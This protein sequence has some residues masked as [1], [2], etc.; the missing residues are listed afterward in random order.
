MSESEH[1]PLAELKATVQTEIATWDEQLIALSQAIHDDPEVAFT[2]YR[3]AARVA[4]VMERAGFTVHR[5]VGDLDTA[6]IA[7]FGSGDFRVALCAEYDALPDIG[8]GCG[9]NII[10]GAAVGA[11]IALARVADEL[12]LSVRL[13]GTP[14]E[15]RG[16][17]KILLL[18][19]G[20]FDDVAV[21][22]MVHPDML[23]IDPRAMSSMAA[24]K[25]SAEYRGVASHAGGMPADGVN[26]GS[27][28]VVAQVA[29]GLLRQHLR[30]GDNISSVVTTA[31]TDSATIP[32][33]AVVLGAVRSPTIDGLT[34]LRKRMVQCFE[35]AAVATGCELQITPAM[36][37]YEPLDQDPWLAERFV[38]NMR[39]VGR[40]V[41]QIASGRIGASTDM[42]NVSRVIPS[43]HP[44]VAIVGANAAGHSK[45]YT[46]VAGSAA[47]QQTLRDGAVCLAWTAIDAAADSAAREGYLRRRRRPSATSTGTALS[48]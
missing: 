23:N 35:G 13:V 40:E 5:G 20:A 43:I 34:A 10:A 9:H 16:G 31:G 19:N 1:G 4:E 44:Q 24:S 47:G 8:H 15:E 26:A 11:A 25:F 12:G 39:T 32:D 18:E 22:M 30:P 37:D 38:R 46:V 3:A 14:A 2:E 21:A 17:G 48:A 28:A 42:G 27:A 41:E 7:D 45:E 36:P 6:V 29:I 33:R